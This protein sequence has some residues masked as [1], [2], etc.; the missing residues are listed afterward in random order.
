MMG[1]KVWVTAAV[2]AIGSGTTMLH[3]AYQERARQAQAEA[4]T[5]GANCSLCAA[6]KA[7]L[8]LMRQENAQASGRERES[9]PD[10]D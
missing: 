5:S 2:L 1:P 8:E 6:H 10:E 7:D 4:Q 9:G 3:A